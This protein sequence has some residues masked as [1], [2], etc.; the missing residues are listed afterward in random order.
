MYFDP[1]SGPE[2]A[3]VAATRR[4]VQPVEERR[5]FCAQCRHLVTHQDER[6]SVQGSHEHRRTNPLGVSFHIGCFRSAGGVSVIG[7]ASTEHTWFAGCAWRIGVCAG[8][9]THLGWRF[10]GDTGAFFGLILARL[11]SQPGT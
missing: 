5:L 8:C 1:A 6:I 7:P 11:V 3:R 10:D 4:A 2:T 9:G